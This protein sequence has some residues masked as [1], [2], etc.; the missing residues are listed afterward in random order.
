MTQVE[1]AHQ[2][3]G[4][5]LVRVSGEVDLNTRL[6]LVEVVGQIDADAPVIVDLSAVRFFSRGGLDWLAAAMSAFVACG[7]RVRVVC[8][9]R[10]PAWRLIRQLKLD[11]HWPLHREVPDAVD[12]L[13]LPRLVPAPS[14]HA[15][16]GPPAERSEPDSICALDAACAMAVGLRSGTSSGAVRHF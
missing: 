5:V 11:G 1:I 16:D 3:P 7:R 6:P 13:D 15:P 10:G 8:P 14:P 9:D 2:A 12:F 4:Y